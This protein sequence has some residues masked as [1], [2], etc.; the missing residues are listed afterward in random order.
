MTTAVASPQNNIVTQVSYKRRRPARTRRFVQ[1]NNTQE[2]AP[3]M[4]GPSPDALYRIL[5]LA[6]EGYVNLGQLK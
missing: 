4:A 3:K 6:A 2:F 1:P 5:V